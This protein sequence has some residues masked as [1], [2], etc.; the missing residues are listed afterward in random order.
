MCGIAG[1]IGGEYPLHSR[2]AN[3][4][5]SALL[6]RGPDDHDIWSTGSQTSCPVTL[7]H[8]RLAIQ[9][10][11][12]AGKQPMR[13]NCGRWVLVFNGEIYN[14]LQLRN[15]LE[16][17]GHRFN[18]KSDTEVLLQLITRYGTAALQKLRGMYAFCLWDIQERQGL[19]GRDPFGIKPLYVWQSDKGT[20]AFA[21]EVRALL[22]TGL[23]A[24]ELD[25]NSLG[26][27]LALGSISEP[28]TL[29]KG[30][31]SLPPGYIGRWAGGRWS[32][33]PHWQASYATGLPLTSKEQIELTRKAISSSLNAHMLSDVPVGL[34]LS[35]GI[36]S[37]V[38]LALSSGH[39]ITTLSI[40]VTEK[41]LDESERARTLAKHFGSHHISLELSIERVIEL[42]PGFLSAVD[43]P[44]IDGFNT[45]CVS[46]LAREHNL[47]VALSG[48]GGDELFGGYPSFTK[49]PQMLRWHQ[50]CG[51]VGRTI[52][53]RLLDKS[54]KHQYQR[55]A[56]FL[57]GAPSAT[58][59]HKCLRGLFS[60]YEI[61]R[62]LA[63]WGLRQNQIPET[64]QD[65]IFSYEDFPTVSDM[66]SW[67]ETSRYMGGQLLRD[68]DVFSMA[69]GLEVRLPFVDT[70]LF[71]TVSEIPAKSRLYPGKRL[72]KRSVPEIFNAVPP[73]A[74]RGFTF[75]F[76]EWLD[77]ENSA[78]RPG[79][80][81][82]PLPRVPIGIDLR[83]WPRRWGLMVLRHW[84]Q[85]HMQI[86]LE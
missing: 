7:V 52:A 36:D 85:T 81:D 21:S 75:P 77:G 44:S 71:R 35:G 30:I 73:I 41:K 86:C 29:V 17:Q 25:I 13:S 82:Y 83:P 5:S 78:L 63:A 51:K 6:H 49:I 65:S 72:L 2:A 19:F 68:S 80:S 18:S 34:F 23:I 74:K 53:K 3:S 57:G 4:M 22:A 39:K 56:A 40:G 45:Y 48:L 76:R 59:A 55:L 14:Q 58:A 47:K 15:E 33:E 62:I 8:R 50:R 69:H 9:D 24:R 32:Q 79:S 12:A 46:A 64:N 84:L 38:L 54:N 26:D 66:I 28:N 60:D 27:F 61:S 43:Q 20:L 16:N 11:S 70:Q 67:L 31:S 42:L 10:L 37:S 1:I